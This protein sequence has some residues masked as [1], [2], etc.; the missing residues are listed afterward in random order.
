[1]NI[2]TFLIANTIIGFISSG[3]LFATLQR[4]YP[5]IRKSTYLDDSALFLFGTIVG[6]LGVFPTILMCFGKNYHGFLIPLTKKSKLEAG[7]NM[8]GFEDKS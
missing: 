1:M 7:I 8:F 3:F 5:E 6:I 2:Q 4:K